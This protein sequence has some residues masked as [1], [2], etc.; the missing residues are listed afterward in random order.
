MGIVR[1]LKSTYFKIYIRY[2]MLVDLYRYW[3][4]ISRYNASVATD[5][6]IEKMQYT[7]LRENHVI[8]KGMSMR[9]PKKGFGQKK[10]LALLNRIDKYVDLYYDKDSCFLKYP[11]ATIGRYIHYINMQG[12]TV[13]EISQHYN[14]II[15]KTQ[16]VDIEEH[17]GIRHVTKSEVLKSCNSD[18]SSLLY[19]RH[20]VR[21]FSKEIP[22]IQL[23]EKAFTL[24]S[25]T[26]SACNRQAWFTHCFLGD[27]SHDLLRWQQGANGFEDEIHCSVLVTASLKGF[28]FYEVHQAYV[29]GGLYAMNLLNA[30]HSL[31]LGTIALSC[32]FTSSKL[33]RLRRMFDIQDS[34]IPIMII[35][36]G[37][38]LDDYNV[39]VSNRKDIA[40]TNKYH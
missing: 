25:R 29:D 26:P 38:L 22:S 32:G 19:S 17:A 14:S 16:L 10:V 15:Q 21:Y 18:F 23:I 5:C 39:A 36:V 6:D 27:K 35:G 9:C 4:L 33:N 20:S 3:Q 11:L 8:E 12:I 40:A 34:E 7:L 13:H 28:L 31:G 30:F 1:F 24:A 37:V 2:S